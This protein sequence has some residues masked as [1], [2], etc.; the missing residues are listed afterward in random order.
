MEIKLDIVLGFLGSGKTSLINL[1]L[2]SGEVENELVVIVLFECGKKEIIERAKNI[3]VIHRKDTD[4]FNEE[5][6][7]F[8]VIE[9]MPNRIIVEYN[10]RGETEKFINSFN[11]IL[12]GKILKQNKV[13]NII[14]SRRAEIYFKNTAKKIKKQI[15][16]SDIVILS[17][18]LGMDNGVVKS[19]KKRIKK[20][21]KY[22]RIIEAADEGVEEELVNNRRICLNTENENL[23]N[24]ELI[25][26]I[27]VF[28]F[29]IGIISILSKEII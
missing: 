24:V 2:K 20:I 4:I 15:E 16:Y 23:S 14:D 6:L 19:I 1:F 13:I 25:I 29:I 27:F 11:N 26:S 9:Y 3:V 22:A 5:L 7:N 8:I 28:L 12:I 18:S 10:G 21:N 17:N